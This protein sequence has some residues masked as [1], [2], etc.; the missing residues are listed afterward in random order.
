LSKVVRGTNVYVQLNPPVLEGHWRIEKLIVS[1]APSGAPSSS[2][3]TEMKK[4]PDLG[5]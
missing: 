1:L 2:T 4:S 5:V 3:K